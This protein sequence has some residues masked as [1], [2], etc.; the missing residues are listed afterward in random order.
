DLENHSNYLNTRAR[1]WELQA[2]CKLSFIHGDKK[3]FNSFKTIIKKKIISLNS[4]KLKSEILDM[5][6]KL[7]PQSLSSITSNINL[8]KSRGGIIDIDF[9]IQYLLLNDA[10]FYKKFAGKNTVKII[11]KISEEVR[12]SELK[13]LVDNFIYL[14]NLQLSIQNI[15][16]TGNNILPDD[17]KKMNALSA[18]LNYSSPHNLSEELREKMKMNRQIFDKFL[19]EAN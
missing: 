12:L 13:N 10:E 14:K 16:N 4:E 1:V 17:S 15:F 7:Y 6:K 11:T 5:R 19:L 3:L 9:V 18:Y 8:K 2:L